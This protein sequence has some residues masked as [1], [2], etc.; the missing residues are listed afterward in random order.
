M[1]TAAT[2]SLNTPNPEP[3]KRFSRSSKDSPEMALWMV[4]RL[5][6]PG[7]AGSYATVPTLSVTARRIF[8]RMSSGGSRA[9]GPTYY[10]GF[11]LDPD[12]NNV[13]AVTHASD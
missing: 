2:S 11:I 7:R 5:L 9:D 3:T 8:L 4:I 12:G 10:G 6:M 13:E 1:T